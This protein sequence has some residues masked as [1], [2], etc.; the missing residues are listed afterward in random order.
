M[1]NHNPYSNNSP[2]TN[3]NPYQNSN[4]DADRQLQAQR[5]LEE[6]RKKQQYKFQAEQA[7]DHIVH[8]FVSA[9]HNRLKKWNLNAGDKAAVIRYYKRY[10]DNEFIS[11]SI[12]VMVITAILSF[13][14]PLA[15]I[16]IFVVF[17]LREFYAQRVFLHICLMIMI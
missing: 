2:Y 13:Y 6:E 12:L 17:M 10:W 4:N 15:I 14:T 1:Q 7:L 8:E 3:N 11:V 5:K 9:Q 16:G